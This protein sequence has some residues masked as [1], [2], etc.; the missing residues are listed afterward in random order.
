M[1]VTKDFVYAKNGSVDNISDDGPRLEKEKP[2]MQR[3]VL[4][5]VKSNLL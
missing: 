1:S 2:S 3:R 4:G 5:C